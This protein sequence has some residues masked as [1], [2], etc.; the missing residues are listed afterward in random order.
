MAESTE[1]AQTSDLEY[2]YSPALPV[3]VGGGTAM[4]A[5]RERYYLET[6]R[7][8]EGQ[9]LRY[10]RLGSQQD[11]SGVPL[12]LYEVAFDGQ[13][14]PVVLFIDM[15][16]EAALKAPAGFKLDQPIVFARGGAA[17]RS[18]GAVAD[19]AGRW[20]LVGP[21]GSNAG[22]VQLNADGLIEI[23]TGP[24]LKKLVAAV[25]E[26][27]QEMSTLDPKDAGR[28]P[29][30]VDELLTVHLERISGGNMRAEAL[31]A[32]KTTEWRGPVWGE[33]GARPP[34]A[35]GWMIAAVIAL[36]AVGVAAMALLR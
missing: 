15:Y 29:A 3:S 27:A 26:R 35:R 22:L 24:N 19:V 34:S 36:V 7:G 12:D 6:L 16:R 23:H 1:H 14:Q 2:G 20:R 5:M 31:P 4:G 18:P 33:E 8:P 28:W 10:H 17:A 30:I 32:F 25:I 21:D 13:G 11:P 9:V